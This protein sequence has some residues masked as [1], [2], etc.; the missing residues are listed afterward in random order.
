MPRKKQETKLGRPTKYS[1]AVARKICKAVA[2]G[3]TREAAAALA[4]IAPSTLHEWR[5]QFSEF[6]GW[7]RKS[8]CAILNRSASQQWQ[9]FH[10]TICRRAYWKRTRKNQARLHV[11]AKK[12]QVL[13]A[14]ACGIMATVN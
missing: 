8:R 9:Q 7:A 14:T 13:A 2:R 6:F 3:S 12:P 5:N 11:E 10:S 1:F 4:G